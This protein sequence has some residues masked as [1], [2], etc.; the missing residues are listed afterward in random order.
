MLCFACSRDAYDP[1][2]RDAYAREGAYD[3]YDSYDQR[4]GGGGGGYYRDYERDKLGGGGYYDERSRDAEPYGVDARAVA[5]R[6]PLEYERGAREG[7]YD[8]SQP[9]ADARDYDDLREVSSGAFY[10]CFPYYPLSHDTLF[11]ILPSF[12]YYPLSHI[13]LFPILPSFPYY[14][15]SH[16][17]RVHG[18]PVIRACMLNPLLCARLCSPSICLL[19]VIYMPVCK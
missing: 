14:P 7:S 1:Y 4:G 8:R 18:Y 16:A 19:C 11:P 2:G 17:M 13:T 6:D 15:L 10:F 3:R 5:P 12:P 9:Y